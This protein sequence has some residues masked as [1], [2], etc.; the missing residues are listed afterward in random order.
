M[1]GH[2][3]A[4]SVGSREAS[5]GQCLLLMTTL[6]MLPEKGAQQMYT[7]VGYSLKPPQSSVFSCHW[8]KAVTGELPSSS[9]DSMPH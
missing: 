7:N 4:Y 9:R 8:F 6:Q 5:R 3:V 1:K 2:H